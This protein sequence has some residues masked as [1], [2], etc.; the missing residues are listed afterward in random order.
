MGVR[1]GRGGPGTPEKP[2]GKQNGRPGSQKT[3]HPWKTAVGK[4]KSPS[5]RRKT[6]PGRETHR[7]APGIRA[8]RGSLTNEVR[9]GDGTP[10]VLLAL[11]DPRRGGGR[12]QPGSPGR[13][14]PISPRDRGRP[15]GAALSSRSGRS[16]STYSCCRRD[17]S[18]RRA[19]F[20]SARRFPGI[21][22]CRSREEGP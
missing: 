7:R 5:G 2:P 6:G 13:P 1:E 21:P 18:R 17:S 20:H 4:A 3:A 14:I 16:G 12:N 10:A 19:A 8:G 22:A 9:Q 15:F 11:L